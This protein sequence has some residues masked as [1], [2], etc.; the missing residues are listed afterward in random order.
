[1]KRSLVVVLMLVFVLTFSFSILAQ[2]NG[3]NG[4]DPYCDWDAAGYWEDFGYA[5]NYGMVD[6]D[7]VEFE[8]NYGDEY[9]NLPE[10]YRG[11]IYKD[12]DREV[13]KGD[14]PDDD[15]SLIIRLPAF[16]YIPC[17]LEITLTGNKLQNIGKSF[18]PDT[19]GFWEGNNN[20]MLLFDN[21]V[22]GFVDDEWMFIADGKNAEV[23]PGEGKFIA[24][25][26]VFCVK[27]NGNESYKYQVW[28]KP[29]EST[30]GENFLDLYMMT[31]LDQG[32]TWGSDFIFDIPETYEIAE[33]GSFE[34]GGENIFLHNFKVPYDVGTRHGE[35][36]GEVLFR[37]VSI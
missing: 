27:T 32:E 19:D 26:D 10:L 37:V 11:G 9:V 14:E 24:G 1:M 23:M 36:T 3:D 2:E 20:Y 6:Y 17:Y 25:C 7:G 4:T 31:S 28:S 34:D 15:Q 12:R 33:I 5:G 8:A 22:G 35:Y 21:E 16:A 30:I 18:G 13:G 29:L